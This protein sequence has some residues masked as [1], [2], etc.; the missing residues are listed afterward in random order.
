MRNFRSNPAQRRDH[1]QELTDKIIVALEAGNGAMEATVG[2]G[3]L[4]RRHGA[5]QRRHRPSLPRHQSLRPRN[6][7]ARF[8]VQRATLVHLPPGR[9]A[10]LA[11]PQ[12]R[13][14]DAGLFLQADRDRG[15]NERRRTGDSTLL[16]AS[17]GLAD[18]A[19]DANEVGEMHELAGEGVGEPTRGELG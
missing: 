11:G 12:G 8:R 19:N 3:R 17:R 7:A 15:P 4:R 18:Q 1:H 5:S 9:R 14:G 16:L 10:R 2:Q 6:V 13:E